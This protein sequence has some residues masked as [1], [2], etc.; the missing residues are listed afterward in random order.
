MIKKTLTAV[1]VAAVCAVALTA[2]ADA[3]TTRAACTDRGFRT[4]VRIETSQSQTSLSYLE[5]DSY[6][7]A[8]AWALRAW[9]TIRATAPCWGS[10]RRFRMYELRADAAIWNAIRLR[11]RGDKAGALA[12]LNQA[13][14]WGDHAAAEQANWP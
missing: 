3:A 4:Q 6:T 10:Y 12:Q 1:C 5:I 11:H 7:P 2:T 9:R 13:S 14:R 8:E